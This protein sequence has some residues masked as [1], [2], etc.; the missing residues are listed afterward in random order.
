MKTIEVLYCGQWRK[1]TLFKTLNNGFILAACPNLVRFS[2]A[3]WREDESS[4]C[5]KRSRK[6]NKRVV[7]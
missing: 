7:K 6:S 3:N 4:R 5:T 1:A 2:P